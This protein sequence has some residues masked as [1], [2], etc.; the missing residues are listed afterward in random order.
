M[1]KSRFKIVPVRPPR[2]LGERIEGIGQLPVAGLPPIRLEI[3][4]T[5]ENG[6][7]AQP[8]GISI[9]AAGTLVAESFHDLSSLGMDRAPWND[10]RLSGMIDFPGFHVAPGSRRGILVDEAAGAFARALGGIESILLE[11]LENLERR[12]S[13]ELDRGLIRDLQRAFRDFYRRSPRYAML[14]VQSEKD[15]ASGPAGAAEG[16]TDGGD[17]E[18]GA[19][20]RGPDEAEPDSDAGVAEATAES[21][22]ESPPEPIQ[23]ATPERSIDLFP[24]GPLSSV[25]IVPANIRV[26]CGGRRT[27]RA[28]GFDAAGRPIPERFECAWEL[29]E[30]LG[31]LEAC[32]ASE[33]MSEARVVLVAGAD[34]AEGVLSVLARSRG[35]EAYAEAPV[36]VVEQLGSGRSREGIPEP[37][38]L[39]HPGA[40]WRSRMLEDRWQVNSGHKDYRAIADRPALKLRYLAMLF[41]KEIVL[42][43]H[44]DPRLE[45]PLEQ[46][47]EVF[48]Y[49]DRNLAS[50]RG[51]RRKGGGARTARDAATGLPG[52]AEG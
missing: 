15:E 39:D 13:E 26:E 33:S 41:A 10:P 46:I 37:E 6:E 52:D 17:G 27:V 35:R 3:Y 11:L 23:G 2:F 14:P 50:K 45:K 20:D 21:A 36:E 31:R 12:K 25:V 51:T 42:R 7:G 44:Q 4:L 22:Q 8:A 32:E 34:P 49:A 19:G 1:R 43:S 16:A 24:P 48:S 29:S 5:G 9:Y 30:R 38:F 18:A 28:E 47:V 40:S